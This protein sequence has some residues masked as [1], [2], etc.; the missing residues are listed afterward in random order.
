[1]SGTTPAWADMRNS[2]PEIGR[3][4]SEEENQRRARVAVLGMTVVKE[5]FPDI[6]PLGEYVKINKINFQVIGVL[7][8]KGSGPGGFR[9]QDDTILLPLNTAMHR[10]LGKE[11][12]DSFDIEIADMAQMDEAEERILAL[13][14]KRHRIPP[15][16]TNAF[17]VHNL[18]EIQ[19]ALSE[20]SRVM[21]MLLASIA[22]ISLLVGGIG[23]MN[24]MLVSVSERTREIGLRKAVGATRF[25]ILAQFLIEAVVISVCGGL[26][27]I[28]LGWLVTALMA[29]LA[30]WTAAVSLWSVLLS[31]FFSA[32]IGV[33][34]GI[35]PAKKASRLSPIIALRYE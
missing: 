2:R 6:N 5:L 7:P 26:A 17:M 18:A 30:G 8:E 21:A 35:W 34:F 20:S 1:M 13:L 10:V 23:I 28:L 15:S 11:H 12:I 25:D 19:E 24:I 14:E 22:A 27:G 3:F 29:S 16:Q 4:F 33:L 32:G 31:F 9:V